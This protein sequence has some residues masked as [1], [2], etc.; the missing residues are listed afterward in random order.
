M[1][2]LGEGTH[3]AYALFFT[4]VEKVFASIHRAAEKGCSRKPTLLLGVN[5]SADSL[6]VPNLPA[7][8]PIG[9]SRSVSH[10]PGKREKGGEARDASLH[11]TV[12][13]HSGSLGDFSPEPRGPQRCHW[14]ACGEYG[15]T[16][17]LSL[18]HLRRV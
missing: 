9:H 7:F 15:R 8:P 10:P 4:K 5:P 6:F 16:I 2:V 18:L 1:S 13:L 3:D 12:Y 17:N 14:R 11:D